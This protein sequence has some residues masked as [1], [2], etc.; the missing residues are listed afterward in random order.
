MSVFDPNS[1]TQKS[2]G[3][4]FF[5]KKKI[6]HFCCD[7]LLICLAP[8]AI[9]VTGSIVIKWQLVSPSVYIIILVLQCNLSELSAWTQPRS[10]S[11]EVVCTTQHAT[12]C[13]YILHQSDSQMHAFKINS[14][15][16]HT[17]TETRIPTHIFSHLK[18]HCPQFWLSLSMETVLC[19]II[20]CS[21]KPSRTWL[22]FLISFAVS[23]FIWF[24]L[25]Q[26]KIMRPLKWGMG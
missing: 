15:N 4:L 2:Y 23:R 9:C 12:V 10:Q 3:R 21:N 1:W 24:I 14:T 18:T 16:A 8:E 13:P 22:G 17:M 7:G 5:W 20:S 26:L 6:N 11:T 25:T 19:F